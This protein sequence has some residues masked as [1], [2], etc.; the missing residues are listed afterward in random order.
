MRKTSFAES[1]EVKDYVEKF[2]LEPLMVDLVNA[3]LSDHS[4]RPLVFMVK[5][6]SSLVSEQELANHGICVRDKS[7]ELAFG[8]KLRGE[9]F[10]DE[11]KNAEL[12]KE[13]VWE[14]S[15]FP[16]LSFKRVCSLEEISLDKSPEVLKK[17]DSVGSRSFSSGSFSD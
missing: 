13:E 15:D 3:T 12:K 17:I 9:S 6:L 7:D 10:A 14:D 1:N 16:E 5:Y 4:D 2:R 11:K 8:N